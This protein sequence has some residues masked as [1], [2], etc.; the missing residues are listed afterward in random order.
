MLALMC[1]IDITALN[2]QSRQIF[3][4]RMRLFMADSEAGYQLHLQDEQGELHILPATRP[5]G[6]THELIVLPGQANHQQASRKIRF[7]LDGMSRCKN[8]DLCSNTPVSSNN[9]ICFFSPP[10]GVSIISDIDDTIKQSFVG[11]KKKLLRTTFL[12]EYRP[13]PEMRDWYQSLAKNADTAFHYVSSSPIQL[14][15]AL[16]DFMQAQQYP[17]GSI[18]L[19]QTTRLREILARP[20]RSKQHK[21]AVITR[22]LHSFKERKFI[23]IGDSGGDDAVIYAEFA[24]HYPQQIA[25]ICIR[26]VIPAPRPRPY[27][28]IFCDIAPERWFVSDKV[29]EMRQ[30]IEG[31]GISTEAVRIIKGKKPGL[32]LIHQ[33]E[34]DRHF[35]YW[36]ETSAARHLADDR[37]ILEQALQDA[38][39]IYFSGIT[40]G[41]LSSQAR[42]VFFDVLQNCDDKFICFDPNIR[43]A[44]WSDQQEL[45]AAISHAARLCHIV[46]PTYSDEAELFGDATP[47]HMA[48]RYLTLGAREVVVKNGGAAAFAQ[49]KDSQEELAPPRVDKVIDA[50]GAGDSFNAAYITA[51]LK[52]ENMRDAMRIGHL[53]ASQVIAHPGAIINRNQL[54][55]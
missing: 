6:R 30:F 51:R 48:D 37:V 4:G 12:E 28:K 23:L 33:E 1:G 8:R 31:N 5:D 18:H 50:T 44:L 32:Y 11:N 55:L 3:Y 45:K 15:P 38:S 54:D 20:G 19:R 52:G 29:H 42:K 53:V 7:Q 36:R 10:R 22:L 14:Y 35:T 49:N 39:L 24:K 43:P 27:E 47:Q 13:V 21:R 17:E 26:H 40:L 46:L 25:A 41:I 2:E 34:G 16:H 9:I